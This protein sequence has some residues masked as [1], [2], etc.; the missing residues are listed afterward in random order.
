MGRARSDPL[1]Y[2]GPVGYLRISLPGSQEE[3]G[4]GRE[5]GVVPTKSTAPCLGFGIRTNECSRRRL[6]EN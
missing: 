3:D 1:G 2:E 5:P 6:N 4:K